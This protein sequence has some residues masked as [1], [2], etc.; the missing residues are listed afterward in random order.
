MHYAGNCFDF[1]SFK[2][3]YS[4]DSYLILNVLYI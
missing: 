1:L 3:L 4:L 2:F